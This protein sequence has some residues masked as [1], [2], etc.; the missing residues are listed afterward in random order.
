MLESWHG[1]WNEVHIF[2]FSKL[3]WNSYSLETLNI[4]LGIQIIKFIYH[5]I[6]SEIIII[7]QVFFSNEWHT[8]IDFI[9]HS[10]ENEII[11]S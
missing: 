9:V 7:L 4:N 2:I 3:F 1:D 10:L 8:L 6:L 11:I 5:L